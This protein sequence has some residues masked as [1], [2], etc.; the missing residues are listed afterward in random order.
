MIDKC[1]DLAQSTFVP[2]R[3]IFDNVIL[4]YELLHTLKHKKV[5]KKGLMVVKLD[6]SKAYDRVKWSFVERVMKKMGFDFD[7]VD[8]L[9]KCV[10][11]VS[12]SVVFNG[13]IDSTFNPS[14]GLR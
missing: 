4:A 1:I 11:T 2:G 5:G 7:W 3:L 8:S 9:M 10:I 13:F 6:M 12:Y 14:R